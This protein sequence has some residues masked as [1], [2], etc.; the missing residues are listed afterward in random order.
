MKYH[1]V[2]ERFLSIS[3]TLGEN[4]DGQWTRRCGELERE[5]R[6]RVPDFMVI[7][8]FGQLKQGPTKPRLSSPDKS[9]NAPQS[10]NPKPTNSTKDALLAESAQ[11]LL[12]LY[13][14]CLPSVVVE[15]RFDLG[16]LLHGF[17]QEVERQGVDAED[18]NEIEP[19]KRLSRVQQLHVLSLL[20][21]GDHFMW[22]SK[23]GE[24]DDENLM[25]YG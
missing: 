14:K 19:A 16:K 20:R 13:Q 1:A 7:I 23:I 3:K 10:D 22:N 21:E 9:N 18:E 15:A 6:K 11:R 5:V 24:F 4:E 12:S 17:V 8:A 2:H 25:I